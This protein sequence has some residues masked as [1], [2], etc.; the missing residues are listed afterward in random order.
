MMSKQFGHIE[1]E[2]ELVSGFHN[3]NPIYPEEIKSMYSE[4]LYY[5]EE[6]NINTK[7][8]IAL[9]SY[10][11]YDNY[12]YIAIKPKDEPCHKTEANLVV[13]F[14]D[15]IEVF[16]PDK[17]YCLPPMSCH[18]DQLKTCGYNVSPNVIKPNK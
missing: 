5:A 14:T 9:S 4:A 16:T 15:H 2:T 13:F 6:H 18:C 10:Q 7:E 8:T 17:F 12:K 3:G 11:I 1:V